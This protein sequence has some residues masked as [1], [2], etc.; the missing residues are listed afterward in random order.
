M[1]DESNSCPNDRK[2]QLL[3]Q[4]LSCIPRQHMQELPN[5]THLLVS[6][7]LINLSLALGVTA[8]RNQ[9]RQFI[10]MPPNMHT[11]GTE[12]AAACIR[13]CASSAVNIH[14][15]VP[16][17]PEMTSPYNL[18]GYDTSFLTCSHGFPICNNNQ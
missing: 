18:T 8:C 10:G 11:R 16:S 17:G 4:S 9:K 6:V 13:G 2:W 15:L 12:L 7:C 3:S 1:N 14:S 5:D